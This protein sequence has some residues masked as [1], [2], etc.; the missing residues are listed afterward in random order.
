[1]IQ[2]VYMS[3]ATLAVKSDPDHAITSILEESR[4]HNAKVG[5][6]GELIYRNG[7]FLQLLEG[8]KDAVEATMGRIVLDHKRHENVRV[9]LKQAMLARIFNEWSMA[10]VKLDN[11]A[12]DLVNSIVPW[13]KLINSASADNA[14]EPQAVLDI[15][16]E[17]RA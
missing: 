14:I 3:F 12:L 7:I 13:Q 5:I 16:Q 11:A 2:I 15:F 17:L 4:A 6:T 9:L 8:S 10:Y 1:M